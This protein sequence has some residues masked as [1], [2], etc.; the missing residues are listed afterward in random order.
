MANRGADQRRVRREQAQLDCVVHGV[1]SSS[2]F[3]R[4]AAA[5][6]A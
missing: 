1:W 2:L 6:G 4:V 3:C 5:Q